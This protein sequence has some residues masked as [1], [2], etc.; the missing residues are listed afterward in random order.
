MGVEKASEALEGNRWAKFREL[1]PEN[2]D[3]DNDDV[4]RRFE[5]SLG[6]LQKNKLQHM[7]RSH[8]FELD[9]E[10]A[11]SILWIGLCQCG[12][13]MLPADVCGLI[14]ADALPYFDVSQVLD[15]KIESEAFYKTRYHDPAIGD[16]HADEMRIGPS[17]DV[18]GGPY[19]AT[20]KRKAVMREEAEKKRKLD[21]TLIQHGKA[22]GVKVTKTNSKKSKRQ[23]GEDEDEDVYDSDSEASAGEEIKIADL[24][25]ENDWKKCKTIK[26]HLRQGAVVVPDPRNPRR[27]HVRSS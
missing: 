8:V 12:I 11:V 19:P 7:R 6:K 21:E 23:G 13:Q 16:D 20:V 25:N 4:S 27:A 22:D 26:M 15:S 9:L 24:Y 5:K 17:W 18:V 14:G 1:Y 2:S 10:L 3:S